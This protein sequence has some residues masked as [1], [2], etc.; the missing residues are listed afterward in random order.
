MSIAAVINTFNSETYLDLVIRS[1]QPL[2]DEIIVCDMYS[3][4]NTVQ[5]AESLGA[6]VVFH[7]H[8]GYAEP[9]RA[10]AVDQTSADWILII[11]CDEILSPELLSSLKDIT[12]NDEVDLVWL[13]REN[14][15]FGG[16]VC[17]A[18]FAADQDIQLRFFRRAKV[19][20]G[21]T[22][23]AGILPVSDAKQFIMNSHN[24]GALIH[25]SHLSINQFVTKLNLYTTIEIDAR[26]Q[27]EPRRRSTI[28]RRAIQEYRH[29][30]F[31][32]GGNRA[33]WRGFAA[34]LLMVV[35]EIVTELKV[36]ERANGDTPQKI[37]SNNRTLAE[38]LLKDQNLS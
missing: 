11:D 30:Y 32:R 25:F 24:H 5:I 15:L 26:K 6:T 36:L 28:L 21:P 27:I 23:H 35:Y 31:R 17:G 4:D 16:V 18:G 13:P 34:S 2:A 14:H 38:K 33:G 37:V 20:L 10:F 12:T 22:V 8:C 3:T 7:E 1:I 29:R 9:A 19:T